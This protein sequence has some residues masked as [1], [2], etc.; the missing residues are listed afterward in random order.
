LQLSIHIDIF[1]ADA[2]RPGRSGGNDCESVDQRN[3]TRKAGACDV[4]AVEAG[5]TDRIFASSFELA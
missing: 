2:Q 3:F 5:A 4:G 1:S